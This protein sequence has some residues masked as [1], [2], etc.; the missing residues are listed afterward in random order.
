LTIGQIVDKINNGQEE[1]QK[2]L[3]GKTIMIRR[4]KDGQQ[5][6][7]DLRVAISVCPKTADVYKEGRNWKIS[8]VTGIVDSC[9][10]YY[11][12]RQ[13]LQMAVYG[14]VESREQARYHS[15]K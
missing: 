6:L 4:N 7:K 1:T 12:E 8:S 11:T 15:G 13:A 14:E 9:P 3:Q 2:H 5:N 10:W